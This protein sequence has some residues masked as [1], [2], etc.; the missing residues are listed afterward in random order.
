M[1]N[2]TQTAISSWTKDVM[3]AST[4]RGKPASPRTI[5]AYDAALAKLFSFLDASGLPSEL[6]S[7]K[8]MHAR[9]FLASSSITPSSLANYDRSLRAIFNRIEAIGSDD[10]GLPVGWK[11]PFAGIP[12]VR[13]ERKPKKPL[14]KPQAVELLKAQ[15]R[16]GFIAARNYAE[17]ATMLMAGLRNKEILGLEL[18]QMDLANRVFWLT[19]TKGGKPRAVFF[20]PKLCRILMAY[21]AKR[22]DR[23]KYL[24]PTRD[25]ATQ[26]RRGLCRMVKRAGVRI[27]RSDLHPHL[28]RHSYGNIAHANGAPIKFLKDM[29]GHSDIKTTMGYI[30]F[31]PE[32]QAD[33]AERF[34]SL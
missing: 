9:K 34:V 28:L 25:G 6:E 3:M 33:M 19:T 1:S 30:T 14:T 11:S 27:G 13:S 10:F 32:E 23:G 5:E 29:Y 20:S 18:S 12:R 17:I 15:P 7:L 16:R 26:Q 24:F 21:L 4:L 22:G 2:P 31:S 8:P